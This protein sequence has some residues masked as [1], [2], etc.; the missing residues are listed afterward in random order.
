[1]Q[2]ENEAKSARVLLCLQA[3]DE[4]IAELHAANSALRDALGVREQSLE[5]LQHAQQQAELG[6]SQLDGLLGERAE[7]VAARREQEAQLAALSQQLAEQAAA[8]EQADAARQRSEAEAARAREAEQEAALAA[9][10]AQRAL[11]EVRRGDLTPP[12]R[13]PCVTGP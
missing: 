1:M 11:E 7:M 10:E 2:E 8:A 5:E 3:K 13:Q 6:A 12:P 9:R 4:E